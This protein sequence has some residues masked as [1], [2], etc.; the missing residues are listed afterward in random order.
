M[1][2]LGFI[3]CEDNL[4]IQQKRWLNCYNETFKLLNIKPHIISSFKEAKKDYKYIWRPSHK[5]F[6][7]RFRNKE[8]LSIEL[9]NLAKKYEEKG[10]YLFPSSND[11]SYYENKRK[12]L[13]RAKE[14]NI[15]I[16]NSIY[17]SERGK[18]N[19]IK[20]KMKF[21]ILFKHPYSCAS[22]GLKIC[23]NES[24]YDKMIDSYLE[25]YGSVI[26]QEQVIITKDLRIN[27]IDTHALCNYW[28]VKS[29][30][31]TSTATWTGSNLDFFTVPFKG[32]EFA[33]KVGKKFG[34]ETGGVDMVWNN[35][36]LKD[37]PL[38][39]EISPIFE[40]NPIPCKPVQWQSFK[41]GFWKH[42]P[43]LRT[44]TTR[45]WNILYNQIYMHFTSYQINHL[46]NKPFPK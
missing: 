23:K 7:G 33:I 3:F 41:Y 19:D 38:L 34:M 16:P 39:L 17:L 2:N 29:N 26:L 37:E 9:S 35:D 22:F 11:L 24:Q 25:E 31:S 6:H 36:N 45:N 5:N 12:I 44:R 20:D 13:N 1:N 32:I 27:Y 43:Y 21:P 42:I 14:A 15:N 28:R 46:I 30:E 10:A 18:N 8:N 4:S 40:L